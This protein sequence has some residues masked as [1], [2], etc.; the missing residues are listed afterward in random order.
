M[1]CLVTPSS[2]MMTACKDEGCSKKAG[3]IIHVNG[4]AQLLLLH[5]AGTLQSS[6]RPSLARPFC[7][8]ALL[9]RPQATCV[10]AFLFARRL[11]LA[12]QDQRRPPSPLARARSATASSALQF[13]PAT[14]FHGQHSLI[15]SSKTI[16]SHGRCPFMSVERLRTEAKN[17]RSA[18]CFTNRSDVFVAKITRSL[19]LACVIKF[20]ISSCVQKLRP[21]M[22]TSA[23]TCWIFVRSCIAE[24]IDLQL[25]HG[26][27]DCSSLSIAA[28][29]DGDDA[30]TDAVCLAP[31]RSTRQSARGCCSRIRFSPHHQET[32]SSEF[33]ALFSFRGTCEHV[34]R[35]LVSHTFLN[36]HRRAPQRGCHL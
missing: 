14:K 33:W 1:P 32:V 13:T 22:R 23:S 8:I 25:L 6:R 28:S 17:C 11:W 3:I 4:A 12:S 24:S 2:R 5:V 16:G 26:W 7:I 34:R 9:E 30:A 19:F 20:M 29:A 35:P 36:E 27:T 15:A 21:S 18:L 10:N 31:L